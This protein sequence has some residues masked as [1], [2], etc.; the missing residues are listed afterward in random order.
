[1]MMDFEMGVTGI[2]ALGV[3][4]TFLDGYLIRM[5]AIAGKKSEHPIGA[6]IY[7]YGKELSATKIPDPEEFR[8][9]PSQGVSARIDG[10]TVL[11]GTEQLMREVGISIAEAGEY[12]SQSWEEGNIGFFMAMDG[13]LVGFI[14]LADQLKPHFA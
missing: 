1:M 3:G 10:K 9:I 13:E 5:A 7:N 12:L 6:A 2:S 4:K 14:A 8:A 11:I